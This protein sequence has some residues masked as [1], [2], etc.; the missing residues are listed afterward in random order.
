[1][2]G[3]RSRPNRRRTRPDR[4]PACSFRI[5]VRSGDAARERRASPSTPMDSARMMR[6]RRERP[7]TGSA[8]PISV[9]AIERTRPPRSGAGAAAR[10]SSCT[11][12]HAMPA[13]SRCRWDC[14]TSSDLRRASGFAVHAPEAP[15]AGGSRPASA[16]RS[17]SSSAS[18]AANGVGADR[19]ACAR[20]RAARRR[21]RRRRSRRRRWPSGGWCPSSRRRPTRR[22]RTPRTG[23]VAIA[24]I[25]SVNCRWTRSRSSA[26][27]TDASSRRV[28]TR[29]SNDAAEARR[30]AAQV[31]ADGLLAAAVDH[32]PRFRAGPVSG[33]SSAGRRRSRPRPRC[34]SPATDCRARSR[35]SRARHPWRGRRPGPAVPAA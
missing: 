23:T 11:S 16:A 24:A 32:C 35:R 9:A 28:R 33:D 21:R 20:T 15:R 13:C 25:S 34:R 8:M 1:M 6:P 26:N 10:R 19:A 22:R 3:D 5:V 12:C 2:N 30:R 7:N 14:A 18:V 4:L 29:P 27:S 31:C 17:R